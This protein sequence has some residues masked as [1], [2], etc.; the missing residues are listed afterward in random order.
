MAYHAI[1]DTLQALYENSLGKP[2]H[3]L[4]GR[5]G[6]YFSLWRSTIFTFAFTE[7]RWLFNL[8]SESPEP[9]EEHEAVDKVE[10]DPDSALAGRENQEEGELI[11]IRI[12]P[13]QAEE[14]YPF[15]SKSVGKGSKNDTSHLGDISRR[16]CWADS[17]HHDPAEVGGGD[18]RGKEGS[19]ADQIPL[20]SYC[21]LV[22]L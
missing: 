8:F 21:P 1:C 10:A 12:K 16:V 18:E 11:R 5:D 3:I 19:F 20:R 2:G 15:P 13:V 7:N 6:K 9:N 14:H 17:N 22:L 4:Q